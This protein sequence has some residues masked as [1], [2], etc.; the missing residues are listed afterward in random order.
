MGRARLRRRHR[1]AHQCRHRRPGRRAH[2]R[3]ARRLRQGSHASA[4]AD[5]DPDR[6]LAAVG[7]LVRLQRRLGARGRRHGGFGHDQHLRRHGRGS[8]GLA[9]RGEGV[10]GQAQPARRRSGAVAGLVAVT[11]A[12]G[13]AGPM[14][15]IVLG[16]VAG[17]VCL[18]FCTAIKN[19]LG[20]DDALDVF[21]V[22]C[23]GGIIGA[24]GTGIL[25]SP[26]LGGTS[27]FD[28]TAN[29]VAEYDMAAQVITQ[30]KA[31]C[32]TLLWSGLGTLRYSGGAE[33]GG[34]PAS[35]YGPGARG[36]RSRRSRRARLQ[37]LSRIG[38][39]V[40]APSD[41]AASSST[42]F[43][44]YV[45]LTPG[46]SLRA[47]FFR[48]RRADTPYGSTRTAAP[49]ASRSSMRSRCGPPQRDAALGRRIAGLG[50]VHEDGAAPAAQRGGAD[51]NPTRRRRRRAGPRATAS[52]RWRGRDGERPVVV[53]VRRGVA[54][55]IGT[56]A[57]A[58]PADAVRGRRKR[59]GR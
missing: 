46:V 29:K 19:A 22:H 39:G 21:G 24:I 10:Q 8:P 4:L 59:S 27:W 32:L 11:P 57:A 53:A 16:I 58:A 30:I 2:G 3:Q 6:R 40:R 17:V 28:Y 52:R 15:A 44:R 12:A 5:H 54:P 7:G 37:L 18:F 43:P 25:A 35:G 56:A 20:Y 9:A 55:A 48:G 49:G 42:P 13:F 1:G 23:I 50:D 41:P 51:C 31:V 45:L 36:P 33:G 34:G 26:T 38:G 47:F 14:G